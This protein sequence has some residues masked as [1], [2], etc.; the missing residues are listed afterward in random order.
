MKISNKKQSGRKKL[1]IAIA[2]VAIL[3]VA[4]GASYYF[5]YLNKQ[6]SSDGTRPANTVDYSPA[7]Q[8]DKI[9]DSS[10]DQIAKQPADDSSTP[11][12]PPQSLSVTIT[13][14]SQDTNTVYVRAIISNATSGE[15]TLTL[16][17][18]TTVIT[19]KAP[20]GAQANY[21]NCQGF[22]VPK[23]ELGASGTWKVKIDVT[24]S[25]ATGSAEGSVEVS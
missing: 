16:T 10:K 18:G 22:N 9:G 15:C 4:A 5:L 14:T 20:V 7:K 24:S 25:A 6:A 23:S 3:L 11:S 19:K 2:G 21:G 1:V 12:T 8:S 13:N 17:H